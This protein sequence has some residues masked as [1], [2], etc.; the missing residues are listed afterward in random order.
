MRG[1]KDSL[2]VDIVAETCVKVFVFVLL[3]EQ[4]T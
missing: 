3:K 1:N 4:F 2:S